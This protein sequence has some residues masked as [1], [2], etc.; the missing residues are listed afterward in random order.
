M[1]P[2]PVEKLEAND[3]SGEVKPDPRTIAAV[4]DT[5]F[6]PI[7]F[8]AIKLRISHI[9]SIA[10]LDDFL[11]DFPIRDVDQALA[12]RLLLID[13]DSLQTLQVPAQESREVIAEL[14]FELRL[15]LN[16]YLHG[17]G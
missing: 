11:G 1:V 2:C 5:N 7:K 17:F 12:V 15:G 3:R 8:S 13:Q 14:R 6:K 10:L 9:V 16:R 4:A